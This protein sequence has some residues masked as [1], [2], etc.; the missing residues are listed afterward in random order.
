MT[1]LT[2]LILSSWLASKVQVGTETI[3]TSHRLLTT[4]YRV[5]QLMPN[6]RRYD[7]IADQDPSKGWSFCNRTK[8]KRIDLAVGFTIG[9]RRISMGWRS[10]LK[11]NCHKPVDGDRPE[12][13]SYYAVA[14]DD[15][16]KIIREWQGA[17]N[18]KKYCLADDGIFRL[19]LETESP[20]PGRCKR[21]VPFVK[22]PKS[23]LPIVT[24]DIK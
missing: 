23:E 19:I 7:L 20:R 16:G 15:Q 11:N 13:L 3:L 24:S 9:S 1:G 2:H 10:A 12:N 4:N 17:A 14:K 5:H 21:L 6:P 18:D 22:I 8:Y